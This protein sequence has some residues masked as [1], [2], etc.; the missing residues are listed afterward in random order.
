MIVL[1]ILLLSLLSPLLLWVWIPRLPRQLAVEAIRDV[2]WYR[3]QPQFSKTLPRALKHLVVLLSALGTVLLLARPDAPIEWIMLSLILNPILIAGALIDHQTGLLP[4]NIS[5]LLGGCA[6]VFQTV[7][8]PDQ[9]VLHVWT[10]L[11]ST[12]VFLL[13]NQLSHFAGRGPAMGGGDIAYLAALAW[14]FLPQQFTWL[15]LLAALSG[16]LESRLRQRPTAVR[17]GPHL[18]AAAALLWYAFPTV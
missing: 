8:A 6:S 5:L 9:L 2:R 15:L 16:L 1:S 18:S 14:L 17:F 7:L 10:S 4:F 13:L 12:L 11:G 3:A